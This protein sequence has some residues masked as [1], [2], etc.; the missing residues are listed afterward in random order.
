MPP[1]SSSFVME[2]NLLQF[3][4][5]DHL[6]PS[7]ALNTCVTWILPLSVLPKSASVFMDLQKAV[8]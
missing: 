8:A 5:Y 1:G 7:F 4:I 3:S 6:Q 2:W